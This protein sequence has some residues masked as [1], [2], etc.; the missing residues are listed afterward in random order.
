MN[1]P[2]YWKLRD[3]AGRFY[4][5]FF[6]P[7]ALNHKAQSIGKK[8][9][10]EVVFFAINV[11]M[12]RYQGICELLS[13][14]PR[15]NC[16]I[17][18]TV[19][20]NKDT[21]V[22][23]DLQHM[24]SY[25]SARGIQYVD[26]NENEPAGYNVKKYIN[27]DIVFYPQP[28][29]KM[30]PENH[31]FFLFKEKLLCYIPYGI[32]IT[33]DDYWQYDLKYHNLA[34]KIYCPFQQYKDR[35]RKVARNHGKNWIVSGSDHLDRYLSSVTTDVWKIKDRSLKRLIWAPH[36]TMLKVSWLEPRSNFLWMS[37]LMLDIA[38]K[39]KDRLQIAFKPH[40][41]LKSELYL[42]PDWGKERTDR[43]YQRWESM[44]NTQLAT[45][46]FIDLFKTSD[47][48]IHDSGSFTIEYLFVNKPVAFTTADFDALKS[49]HNDIARACLDQYYVVHNEK[50]LMTFIKD[51][52]LAGYDTMKEQRTT[53]FQTVLKSNVRG[54]TSEFI[55]ND[56]K[57]SLG[58]VCN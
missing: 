56:I 16:H 36:F 57:S 26:Y 27:P 37:Q 23:E 30:Y 54:N 29:E 32:Y 45:G 17:V 20:K 35:A 34:W 46:D 6:R 49:E 47:A 31:D 4:Y 38:E 25:F 8:E 7:L 14:E 10:I 3:F 24:R 58:L 2:F 55:V 33:D 43:Y 18:L 9:K 39:Y 53:F 52:V 12:W 22:A 42:H 13:K 21:Q 44:E 5:R 48:M 41:R 28:Y 1:Y 15:F 50:E 19:A 51:V 11:A 40:P